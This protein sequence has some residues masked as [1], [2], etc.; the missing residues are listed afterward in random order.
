VAGDA[1]FFVR[2]KIG[3][4]YIVMEPF[5]FKIFAISYFGPSGFGWFVGFFIWIT[6]VKISVQFKLWFFF[7]LITFVEIYVIWV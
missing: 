5:D 6:L 3:K 7:I 4:P 1:K 2:D